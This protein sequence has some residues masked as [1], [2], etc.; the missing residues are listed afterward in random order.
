VNKELSCQQE[1]RSQNVVS[2]ENDEL[3]WDGP[4]WAGPPLFPNSSAG[5]Q[6]KQDLVAK[7]TLPSGE[8]VFQGGIPL[9]K[10]MNLLALPTCLPL[11]FQKG[12][13]CIRVYGTP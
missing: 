11:P 12:K 1:C 6:S 5:I 10:Q 2:T 13:G 7:P 9:P 3:S 8:A 4:C